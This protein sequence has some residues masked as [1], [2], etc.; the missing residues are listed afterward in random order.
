MGVRQRKQETV[1]KAVN[2]QHRNNLSNK[3]DTVLD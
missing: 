2:G 3:I 1:G